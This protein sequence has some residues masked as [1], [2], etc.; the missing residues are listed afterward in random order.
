M[1]IDDNVHLEYN[2]FKLVLWLSMN[3]IIFGL[4]IYIFHEHILYFV[5]LSIY[6]DHVRSTNDT[7]HNTISSLLIVILLDFL[8][9]KFMFFRRNN[10]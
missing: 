10:Y 6:F 1:F 3:P 8:T 4:L 2:I 7:V 9:V 5:L